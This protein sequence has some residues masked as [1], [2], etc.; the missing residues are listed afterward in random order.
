MGNIQALWSTTLE[1]P[2]MRLT[3]KITGANDRF[4]YGGIQKM[5]PDRTRNS[6]P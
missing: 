4:V 3:N 2:S 6:K 1:Y 5:F